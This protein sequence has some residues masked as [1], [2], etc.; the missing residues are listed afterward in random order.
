MSTGRFDYIAYSEKSQ[1]LSDERKAVS[2]RFEDLLNELPH[3]R[4][5]ALALTKLEECFMWTGKAIRNWQLDGT[6]KA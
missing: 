6:E 5:K 4:E 2:Q 1:A 3:S